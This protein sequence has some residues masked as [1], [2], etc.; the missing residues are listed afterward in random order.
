M[1][2]V[3]GFASRQ[4]HNQFVIQADPACTSE[5]LIETFKGRGPISFQYICLQLTAS[6]LNLKMYFTYIC[7]NVCYKQ[8]QKFDVEI[9]KKKDDI[10]YDSRVGIQNAVR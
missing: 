5:R 1:Y 3:V 2:N 10:N 4:S 9:N 8:I 6:E 7:I